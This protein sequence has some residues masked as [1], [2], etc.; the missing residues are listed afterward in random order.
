MKK[1]LRTYL[2]FMA[3]EIKTQL[4]YRG[5]VFLWTFISMFGSFI[6]Y[7][8]WMAIYGSSESGVIGNLTQNEMVIY[9]FMVYITSSLVSVSIST[10]IGYDVVEGRV[11]INLI[12]PIDYRTS[13]IAEAFGDSVYHMIIPG[14][15]IW[16]GLEAYK[17]FVLG[18]IR[19]I[20]F[21]SCQ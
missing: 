5:S 21:K 1:F 17:V 6:S 2:P 14:V 13:L 10:W 7:F 12:K 11:A 19:I 8:L 4:A 15:F 9:I 16:G 3:N 18:I 20:P